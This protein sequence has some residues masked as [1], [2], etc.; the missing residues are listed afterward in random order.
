MSRPP[1]EVADIIRSAGDAFR[2]QYG[3]SLTWP[4][5]K[6][7]DA[8]VRCRT[9]AL[10]GH[11][12][13]CLS[14]GR[15]AISYNSCRNRHCPKCQSGAR[16]QW[17]ARRQQELL[18]VGYYHLVFSVPHALVPLMWQNKRQLFSLLFEASAATLL[19]VGADPKHLGAELG[20][21]SILHTWGQTLT[22]HPH[23]HCVVPG[24]G[25]AP[26]HSRWIASQSNF[27]LPVKV[28]SRVFRRKFI[29]GLRQLFATRQ[30]SFFG[31]CI[32]LLGEKCFASFLCQL[33][34]QDWVVYAKPPFGGPEHVLH[35]L[36]RYT[37]RVA[38]SNHR[39]LAVS[40]S[41]VCFR[42]KDYAHGGKQRTM[43]LTPQEFLRR[44]VQH[45]LPRG[46][47]RIRYFGWLSNRLRSRILPLCRARL[48]QAPPAEV[49]ATA[50][51]LSW[52]CTHCQ[53]LMQPVEKLSAAQLF[54]AQR[55]EVHVL[56]S[57]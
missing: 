54:F 31:E 49:P 16:D 35:Y 46:F 53:G 21:L 7:L 55:K 1:F 17:L 24:G 11:R 38:I 56:D 33:R 40:A 12:D 39:L 2:E 45:V 8:I 52:N 41:E 19:D 37:H 5:H 32:P 28:L 44:F 10:G 51:Q 29:A 43:T 15:E 9:A 25:L 4:Q 36:A 48:N 22:P 57:S 42:W 34:R 23:I 30:L 6:V 14:C 26:D 27:F 13:Q 3:S 47:P 20:F 50:K 18:N